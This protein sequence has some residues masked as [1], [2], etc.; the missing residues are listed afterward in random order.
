MTFGSSC[1]EFRKMEGLTNQAGVRTDRTVKSNRSEKRRKPI[2]F[3][4][5]SIYKCLSAELI[6]PLLF[7]KY[8]GL[9]TRNWLNLFVF[10]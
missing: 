7:A 4:I 5:I 6:L 9:I 1:L 3:K 10:S 8:I 2:Q